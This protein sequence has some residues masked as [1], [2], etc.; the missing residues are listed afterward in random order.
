[1]IKVLQELTGNKITG[2]E[3]EAD[4]EVD[5]LSDTHSS[6]LFLLNGKEFSPELCK[7][8][9]LSLKIPYEPK[10]NS[11][12]DHF[13][14]ISSLIPFRNE[15]MVRAAGALLKFLDKSAIEIFQMEVIDGQ[16]PVVDVNIC[17]M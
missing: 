3:G 14:F 13:L 2:E 12:E 5:R 11:P 6:Q 4:E 15:N 17:T 16:V 7:Q 8:R 10:N 9:I 1:M